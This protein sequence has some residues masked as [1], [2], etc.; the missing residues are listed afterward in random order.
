MTSMT[1]Y[2]GSQEKKKDPEPLPPAVFEAVVEGLVQL[3]LADLE[4]DA[5]LQNQPLTAQP[6]QGD[7]T[8]RAVRP[9]RHPGQGATQETSHGEAEG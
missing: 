8:A 5:K 1:S 3:L 6:A 9:S 7:S 2:G 4:A